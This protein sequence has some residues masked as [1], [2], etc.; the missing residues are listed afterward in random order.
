MICKSTR[1]VVS[2]TIFGL[3]LVGPAGAGH[4]ESSALAPGGLAGSGHITFSDGRTENIHCKGYHKGG[5]PVVKMALE[6]RS[7]TSTI[8]IR[9]ISRIDGQHAV[10]KW[11]ALTF[12]ASGTESR[13]VG[14]GD[15]TAGLTGDGSNL[16]LVSLS[17]SSHF[18]ISPEGVSLSK[19]HIKL[20]RV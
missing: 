12:D 5:S 10:G 7:H 17:Q 15:M 11:K 8:Y 16:I 9:S 14:G 1:L 20:S 4:A 13:S 19:A 18:R 2:L 6:C 3:A